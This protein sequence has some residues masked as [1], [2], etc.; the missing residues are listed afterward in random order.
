MINFSILNPSTT[1][2]Y[3]VQV[4]HLLPVLT[5]SNSW[6]IIIKLA[7]F[8]NFVQNYASTFHKVHVKLTIGHKIT[9]PNEKCH[10]L[11]LFGI[12]LQ[13]FDEQVSMFRQTNC[14]RSIFLCSTIEK[15]CF[16]T[17]WSKIKI[18]IIFGHKGPPCWVA[19]IF[20]VRSGWKLAGHIL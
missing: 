15:T 1:R 18:F 14:T 3:S 17:I 9:R 7:I 12:Q 13:V 6:W 5:W 11:T 19:N 20:I 16:E 4:S 10:D 8:L 2:T